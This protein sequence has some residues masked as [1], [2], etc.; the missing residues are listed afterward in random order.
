MSVFHRGFAVTRH[1]FN[2]LMYNNRHHCRSLE[3]FILTGGE[4]EQPRPVCGA[5][6]ITVR[7][8]VLEGKGATCH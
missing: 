1:K 5:G 3:Y 8:L 4:Q 6:A 7:Q 2:G